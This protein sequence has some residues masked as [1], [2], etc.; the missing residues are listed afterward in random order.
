[1][2]NL[3]K[4]FLWRSRSDEAVDV[5]VDEGGHQELAVEPIHDAAV[6]RNDIAEILKQIFLINCRYPLNILLFI[7]KL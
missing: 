4:N 2:T 3:L 6:A 7:K 1:L 5:D